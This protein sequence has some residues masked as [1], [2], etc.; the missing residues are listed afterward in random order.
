MI[1]MTNSDEQSSPKYNYRETVSQCYLEIARF[2]GEEEDSLDDITS[3]Q[4]H[5]LKSQASLKVATA[6]VTKVHTELAVADADLSQ[7]SAEQ[8]YL[9]NE[10]VDLETQLMDMQGRIDVPSNGNKSTTVQQLINIKTRLAEV[11]EQRDKKCLDK[12]RIEGRLAKVKYDL[13]MILAAND[14][15]N[16]S[17]R[18]LRHDRIRLESQLRAFKSNN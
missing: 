6:V 1:A 5:L 4:R 14:D 15:D 9:D 8:A 7:A 10:R 18:I 13:A 16:A 17:L 2:E 3:L 11:T 12:Q